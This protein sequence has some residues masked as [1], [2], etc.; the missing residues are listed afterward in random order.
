MATNNSG[1]M[2]GMFP[3]HYELICFIISIKLLFVMYLLDLLIIDQWFF[4]SI[5]TLDYTK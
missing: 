1:S 4:D 3:T 5:N 2:P